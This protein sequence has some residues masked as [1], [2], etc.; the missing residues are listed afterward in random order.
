MTQPKPPTKDTAPPEFVKMAVEWLEEQAEV[1]DGFR[2]LLE[3]RRCSTCVFDGSQRNPCECPIADEW[4]EALASEFDAAIS[5]RRIE[6][7]QTLKEG[8]VPTQ[9][10]VEWEARDLDKRP[11]QAAEMRAEMTR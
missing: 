5:D 1:D 2:A 9:Y 7:L 10:V 11:Q 8:R 4:V 3:R 6:W